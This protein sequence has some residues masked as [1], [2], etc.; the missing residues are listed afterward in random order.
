VMGRDTNF[1]FEVLN[2]HVRT[3]GSDRGCCNWGG[4]DL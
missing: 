2:L 3:L 1:R 4:F